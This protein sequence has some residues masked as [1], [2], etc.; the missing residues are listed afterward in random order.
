[1]EPPGQFNLN[2]STIVASSGSWESDAGFAN[3]YIRKLGHGYG[4]GYH[5]EAMPDVFRLNL[6]DVET[7]VH[8]S[9]TA[10]YGALDNDDMFMYMGG[11]TA[12]IRN[13][14]GKDAETL[15]TNTRDPGKP[16][17]TSLDKFI[18]QEFRSR[19]VNPEWIKGMQKEGYAGAG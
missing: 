1:D 4:N 2:T 13:V 12:A 18:G 11:L 6:A 3:D 16:E 17:M 7:V 5:G 8:S 14:S 10:L 9:S 15:V 19:Y